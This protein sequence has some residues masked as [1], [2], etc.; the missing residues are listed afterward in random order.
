[1][2]I[3]G[4]RACSQ[5]LSAKVLLLYLYCL[6]FDSSVDGGILSL[7]AADHA[8][9]CTEVEGEQIR[10]HALRI[11]SGMGAITTLVRHSSKILIAFR[12]TAAVVLSSALV[13]AATK[14]SPR[15]HL[16]WRVECFRI[17]AH[18]RNDALCGFNTKSRY[19]GQAYN[20]SLVLFQTSGD[21]LVQPAF[22]YP[23]SRFDQD[24]EPA[25][26]IECDPVSH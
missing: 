19:F 3:A 21:H 20:S 24:I 1:V 26:G 18:F 5:L 15:R 25:T 12:T 6:I 16:R 4:P 10:N 11:N 23:A 2:R 14:T 17:G 7:G 13:F 9:D 8:S 22:V